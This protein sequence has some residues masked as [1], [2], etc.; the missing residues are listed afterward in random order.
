VVG[1]KSFL[2]TIKMEI[3]RNFRLVPYERIAF[4]KILAILKTENGRTI[5]L[6]ELEKTDSIRTSAIE[7][8]VQFDDPSVIDALTGLFKTNITDKEK[9]LILGCIRKSQTGKEIPFLMDLIEQNKETP[10]SPPVMQKTFRVLKNAGR[11]SEEVRDYLLSLIK[12]EKVHESLVPLAVTALSSFAVISPYED[13]LKRNDEKITYAVYRALFMLGCDLDESSR[14]ANTDPEGF[15]TY[16]P[17]N[18]DKSILDIRVLLGKMAPRFDSYSR[19]VKVA[20]ISAMIACNHREFLVYIMKALTSRDQELAKMVM[21]TIYSNIRRL[22]DPDKLLRSLIALSTETEGENELIIDIFIKYFSQDIKT[23]QFHILRDKLFNYIIVTLESYFEMFRK[24]FMIREVIEKSYPESFQRIRSLILEKFTPEIKKNIISFL[25]NEN[26]SSIKGVFI[27]IAKWVTYISETEEED[28]ALLLQVLYDSD[29]KSRE[30]SATRIDDLRFEKRYLRKRIIRLCRII[31]GLMINE[32]ASTLVNIYNYLKKYPDEELLAASIHALSV[33]NYSYMLGEVEVML[34]TGSEDDQKTA[35]NLLSLFHEQRSMNI[36]IDYLNPRVAESTPTLKSLLA[37]LLERD[38]AGNATINGILK[39]IIESNTDQEMRNMA[40]LGIGKGGFDG[41]I[42][43]LNDL[44]STFEKNQP[45]DVIIRA[46]GSILS[47]NADINKRIMI[48]H[49]Q[50]YLKDPGIKVRIYACLLLVKLG[51]RDA[52]RFVRDMLIIKNKVIQRDILTI[53][54]ELRSVE[55]AFFLISLLKEEYGM[56]GDIIPIIEKLPEED[57]K[58]IDNFVVNIFRKFDATDIDILVQQ[59]DKDKAEPPI[60]TSEVTLLTIDLFKIKDE[61]EYNLTERINLNMRLKSLV[62]SIV[63][64]NKGIISQIASRKIMAYFAEPGQAI[65]AAAKISKNFKNY[66]YTRISELQIN[67]QAYI[68]TTRV[69]ILNEEIIQFPDEMIINADWLPFS[70]DIFCNSKTNSLM[71]DQY[72]ML[73]IPE[74]VY[75]ERGL[76]TRLYDVIQPVNFNIVS[77]R[78]FNKIIKD[79]EEKIRMQMQVE[80]DMKKMRRES[81]PASSMA[82]ARDLE[83]IGDHLKAQLDE[84]ER[85]IQRRSTDREMIKNVRKMLKN[86]HNLY[87]VEISR[88]IIE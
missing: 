59:R 77:E 41:D 46:M 73:T 88:I 17:E 4:H 66:N 12:D 51:D 72:T 42:E 35:L 62:S 71:H 79:E 61:T 47:L 48:R 81:R 52:V 55:F 76:F 2:Q 49:L 67:V 53:M 25:L 5:L 57:L 31:E 11:D 86:L 64:E 21:Y 30:N 74:D 50:E 8:L 13:L 40:V 85:Y 75:Q 1:E 29:K 36:I 24:E 18:E 63:E 60:P 10:L 19:Q 80:A 70:C 9:I 56:S 82:I 45:K 44:F 15:Y 39:K 65:N 58:E 87:K 54:G 16:S 7:T 27:D 43:Y 83:D 32:A 26:V 84:I 22:K 69:K 37:I 33:L 6:K 23:R 68:T 3:S 78:I 38:I 14:K 28:L 34:T 20:F